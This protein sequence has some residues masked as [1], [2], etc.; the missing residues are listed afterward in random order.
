MC[1]LGEECQVL[2]AAVAAEVVVAA[3]LVPEDHWESLHLLRQGPQ[4]MDLIPSAGHYGVGSY[5]VM[6]AP[7]DRTTFNGYPY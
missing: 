4:E 2:V 5:D 3:E 6:G 7:T 1:C